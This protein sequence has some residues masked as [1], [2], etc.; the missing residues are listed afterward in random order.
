MFA[1]IISFYF[2]CVWLYLL[3]IIGTD[4]LLILIEKMVTSEYSFCYEPYRRVPMNSATTQKDSKEYN[5]IGSHSTYSSWSRSIKPTITT[6]YIDGTTIHG[7]HDCP[8]NTKDSFPKS[9]G[10]QKPFHSSN[11]KVRI[12]WQFRLSI[13]FFRMHVMRTYHYY[14]S[15]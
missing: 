3:I 4:Q 7:Q 15:K 14:Q 11:K 8:Y 6:K 12:T 2:L 10:R 9:K 13:I 5:S 1:S